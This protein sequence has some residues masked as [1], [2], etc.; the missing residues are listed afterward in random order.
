VL[1]NVSRSKPRMQIMMQPKNV[2][3]ANLDGISRGSTCMPQGTGSRHAGP[4]TASSASDG[5]SVSHPRILVGERE[6][7]DIA[8]RRSHALSSQRLL[9]SWFA[10]AS[11]NLARAP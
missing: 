1:G 9:G 7:G 4:H 6:G 5:V 2:P 10:Q 3:F 11:A 8:R